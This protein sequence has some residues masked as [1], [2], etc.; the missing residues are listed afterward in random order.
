MNTEQF[1]S[2]MLNFSI[3][4]FLDEDEL[5]EDGG[6]FLLLASLNISENQQSVIEVLVN[7]FKERFNQKIYVF[8]RQDSEEK[9][10]IEPEELTELVFN[11]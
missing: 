3:G 4:I 5:E 11:K 7:K 9:I 2:E 10:Y 8:N 1:N 6:E